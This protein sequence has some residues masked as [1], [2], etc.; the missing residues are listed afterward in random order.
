MRPSFPTLRALLAALLLGA[1]GA[2]WAAPAATAD[3]EA[4]AVLQAAYTRAVAP[5]EQADLYR[6]LIPTVLE[7]I[8]RSHA[9][10]NDLPALATAITARMEA[11]PPGG[12]PSA[13]F[14]KA[15][16]ETLR[17]IDS[18]ARYID[19]R[20]MADERSDAT[21]SFVG[22]GIEVQPTDGAVRIV[23][24]IPGGP[25][26]RAGLL[27]GD[28]IVRIDDQPLAGLPLPEAVSRMRGEAGT[29]VAVTI[30]RAGTAADFTVS[31][32]RDTIRRELLR[33]S[34]EDQ[35]LVVRLASF[36]GSA[37][38]SLAKAVADAS[39]DRPPRAVILDLRGNPGGLL[40]EGIRVADAFLGQ[41]EIVSLRGS[42]S[43][44]RR[45]WQADPDELLPG[46]PMVVLIDGR[47]ASASELVADALQHHGR[48]TVMGQR[49]YGKGSVQTTF[50]LGEQKGALKMTTGLYHGPSGQTV[51]RIG[52]MPDIELV[53][54]PGSEAA[55]VIA[56]RA[57][58]QDAE[59]PSR[60]PRARVDQG[61]CAPPTAPDPALACALAYLVGSPEV[62]APAAAQ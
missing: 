12:D 24:P 44:L 11:L 35:V 20:G 27:A 59:A 9:T 46:L 49:S 55:R 19:T 32:T 13:V 48:A 51:Q 61:R 62:F 41:G 54:A 4:I 8:R 22:I 16:N 58:E 39:A 6:D 30:R 52:V 18:Y 23:A 45:T 47:S 7:R 40:R 2:G 36:S 28:L 5:G 50:S 57:A 37:T 15:V 56:E 29:P 10:A 26:A 14:R 43:V 33:W 34:M 53:A 25:A 1:A 3:D 21:G 38:A 60:K 42:G 31:L 17:P